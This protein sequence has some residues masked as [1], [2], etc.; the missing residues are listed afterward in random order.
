MSS[1]EMPRRSPR[2]KQGSKS[3]PNVPKEKNVEEK[4]SWVKKF[5][6]LYTFKAQNGHCNVPTSD[7]RSKS[8]GQWVNQQRV[9]YKRNTLSSN[10]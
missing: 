9:A 7:E 8:L 5:D 3:L 1:P 10:R 6:E 2:K 4:P